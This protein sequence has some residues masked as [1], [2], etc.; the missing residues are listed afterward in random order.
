VARKAKLTT[1]ARFLGV[2]ETFG[3]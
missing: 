1:V 3:T 2:F